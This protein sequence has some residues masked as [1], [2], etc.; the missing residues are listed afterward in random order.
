MNWL[1]VKNDTRQRFIAFLLDEFKIF[2]FF[3]LFCTTLGQ[4]PSDRDFVLIE[5]RFE[6]ALLEVSDSSQPPALLYRSARFS[7]S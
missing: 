2:S 1:Y 5:A 3:F 4:A 7:L 6:K